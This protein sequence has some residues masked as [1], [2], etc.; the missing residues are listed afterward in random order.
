MSSQGSSSV[1]VLS[2]VAFA[3]DPLSKEVS[4]PS[5]SSM[6]SAPEVASRPVVKGAIGLAHGLAST[7]SHFSEEEEE[8]EVAVSY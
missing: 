3:G 4:M 6:E 7:Y 5:A 1:R 2:G 8:D